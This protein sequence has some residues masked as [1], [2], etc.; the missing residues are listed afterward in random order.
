[1]KYRLAPD[2]R[3]VG[4]GDTGALE[5]RYPLR[6]IHC[7]KSL[8]K[9]VSS[10]NK[11]EIVSDSPVLEKL[12]E[13]GFLER[14]WRRVDS[15]PYATISVI[16][17]V[18]DRA[19]ELRS[20]LISLKKLRYPAEK[21]EIIVV[22]DGSVDDSVAIAGDFGALCCLSGGVG[23]GPAAA[24]NRGARQARGELLAF[25]D[26]DCMAS[27]GWLDL[28]SLAF[29]DV[30]VAAVGGCV[31]GAFKESALDRY[32]DVMSS[33]NLGVRERWGGGGNDTFYLPSCNLLVR[34]DSFIAAGGFDEE[35]QV[36]EDVDLSYRLRDVGYRI[37]YLTTGVV[38]HAHRN[39]L[40]SF[41]SRRFFYGTSEVLLQERHGSRPKKMSTPAL[42]L[43]SVLLL[44]LLPFLPIWPGGGAFLLFSADV[45]L[46]WRKVT[47]AGFL[48][49]LRGRARTLFSLGYYLSYHLLRYYL[50]LLF[51]LS[52]LS[53]GFLVITL[54]ILFGVALV[55][56]KVKNPELGFHTFVSLY[57]AEQ[58]SYGCGVFWG[59]LKKYNFS[60]YLVELRYRR[61]KSV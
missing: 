40:C 27:S 14:V 55:D 8:W 39:R 57:T 28:L 51:C 21:L 1:M 36:G 29:A 9:L 25:I 30:Q 45:F 2:V 33:L 41:M 32:E 17:P 18:K 5:S 42:L 34:K 50:P 43:A 12:A 11:G 59:C 56:Y 26:S 7:N 10:Q 22:D 52:I 49:V 19:E 37:G 4:Q 54:L 46:H 61:E 3:L 16:I 35:L 31:R 58:L 44:P 53:H 60:S 48:A 15:T 24:R 23:R 6:I 47:G 20:C 13:A 38:Y